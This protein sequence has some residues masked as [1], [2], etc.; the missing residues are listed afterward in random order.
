M[1]ENY[2]DPGAGLSQL[3]DWFQDSDFMF[4]SLFT[5][6]YFPEI[7]DTEYESEARLP[8]VEKPI[9]VV[10]AYGSDSAM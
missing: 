4:D 6:P 8:P 5:A 9:P 10:R 7:S 1:I 2:I 3:P